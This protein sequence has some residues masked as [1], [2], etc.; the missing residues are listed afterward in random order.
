M[1]NHAA[2]IAALLVERPTCLDCLAL[3]SALTF[4]QVDHY[5]TII[6]TSLEL[7]R[8]EGDRCRVCGNV[9]P[10][11]SLLRSVN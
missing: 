4:A 8:N 11:F 9:G 2:V 1:P 10:V 5:L 6:G 3:K 7:V